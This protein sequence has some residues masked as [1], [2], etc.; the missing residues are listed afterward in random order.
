MLWH[1]CCFNL[2][3]KAYWACF[4]ENLLFWACILD[5]PPWF[6][7]WFSYWIF[8]LLNF[9][10][11]AF[12]LVFQLSYIFLACFSNLLVCYCKITWHHWLNLLCLLQ[13]IPISWTHSSL[14]SN[15]KMHKQQTL[16]V[17]KWAYSLC[18]HLCLHSDVI[19]KKMRNALKPSLHC[20]E[21]PH[22]IKFCANLVLARCD[23]G[24]FLM[25]T[26]GKTV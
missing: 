8:V 18:R 20:N 24:T 13:Y 23:V 14:T 2:L 10:A 25:H 6:F 12:W 26:E 22:N 19:S 21:E 15:K 5:L 9:P 11:N 17:Y 1:F 3:L 16:V 7:I 4:C